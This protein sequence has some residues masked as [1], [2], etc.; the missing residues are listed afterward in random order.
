MSSHQ[1]PIA[2]RQSAKA[3]ADRKKSPASVRR[4]LV[5]GR[6]SAFLS[7]DSSTARAHAGAPPTV[8]G[9]ASAIMTEVSAGLGALRK[10]NR[11]LAYMIRD[12][13]V[14]CDAMSGS[15]TDLRA[16]LD[17]AYAVV[18]AAGAVLDGGLTEDAR[19]DLQTALDALDELEFGRHLTSDRAPLEAAP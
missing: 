12:L 8:G 7:G 1:S 16:R 19:A 2:N 17:K 18:R 5:H 4:R 14:A 11:E 13:D 3:A 9:I 15:C 6:S 10:E